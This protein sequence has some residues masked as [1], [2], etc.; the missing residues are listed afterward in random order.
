[1]ETS[2]SLC[3]R[4]LAICPI[5]FDEQPSS[6]EPV[7]PPRS[8]GG[9]TDIC[10]RDQ[11]GDRR[12][13]HRRSGRSVAEC[14]RRDLLRFA[15]AR[16]RFRIEGKGRQAAYPRRPVSVCS[17]PGS[18]NIRNAPRPGRQV[19]T[20]KIGFDVGRST[21]CQG[22]VNCG[23]R[24]RRLPPPLRPT[25]SSLPATAVSIARTLGSQDNA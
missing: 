15:A 23:Q 16:G 8:A 18:I 10:R 6:G 3:Q 17:R 25:P 22:T 11:G 13:C 2:A 1:V 7:K 4:C 24:R 14:R 5:T 20:E 9:E 21:A 19:K 12:R